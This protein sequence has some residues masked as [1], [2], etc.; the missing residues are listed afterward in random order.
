MSILPTIFRAM[1]LGYGAIATGVALMGIGTAI[2]L[3]PNNST[4]L[5]SVPRDMLALA[6]GVAVAT[7]QVGV[8]SGIAIAGALFGSY[9]SHYVAQFVGRGIEM[10]AARKIASIAGFGDAILIGAAVSCAGIATSVVRAQGR[11]G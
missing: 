5:G 1:N 3:A 11:R 4:V 10:T 9:Q 6:S 8:S 7:R 2:F